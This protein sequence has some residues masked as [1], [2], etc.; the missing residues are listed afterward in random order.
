MGSKRNIRK[1]S[2]EGKIKFASFQEVSAFF[3]KKEGVHGYQIYKCAFCGG[4]H[5]GH[6]TAKN[7]QAMARRRGIDG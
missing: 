3:A 5:F 7:K 6:M 2:C 4:W 1:R